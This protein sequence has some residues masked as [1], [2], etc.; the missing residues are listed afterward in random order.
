MFYNYIEKNVLKNMRFD[1]MNNLNVKMI[2]YLHIFLFVLLVYRF[3]NLIL[4]TMIR[5]TIIITAL[6]SACYVIYIFM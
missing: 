4:N 6:A 1:P 5:S 2:H 3:I